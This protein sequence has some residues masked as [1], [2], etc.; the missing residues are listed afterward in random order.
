[1]VGIRKSIRQLEDFRVMLLEPHDVQT[2]TSAR[3]SENSRPLHS[4]E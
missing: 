3:D 4:A 2:A 1:M